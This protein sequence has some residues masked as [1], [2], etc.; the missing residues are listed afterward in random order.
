MKKLLIWNSDQFTQLEQCEKITQLEQCENFTQLEPNTL[1]LYPALLHISYLFFQACSSY[2]AQ[3]S[4]FYAEQKASLVHA[5]QR[6]LHQSDNLLASLTAVQV[7]V[8]ISSIFCK[9]VLDS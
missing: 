5:Y 9:F 3:Q 2:Y 8:T 7:V 4:V 1:Q 6:R